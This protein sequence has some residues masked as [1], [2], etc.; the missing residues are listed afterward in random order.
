MITLTDVIRQSIAAVTNTLAEKKCS[1][2]SCGEADGK[3][4]ADA[5]RLKK[6]YPEFGTF[7]SLSL[8]SYFLG[9]L[10][11]F[12]RKQG[13]VKPDQM[14]AID[15]MKDLFAYLADL[16]MKED[17]HYRF[18]TRQTPSPAAGFLDSWLK[19]AAPFSALRARDNII[20]DLLLFCDTRNSTHLSG[21]VMNDI[22]YL[23]HSLANIDERLTGREKELL[24][25][26]DRE[27]AKVKKA[28][29]D[30]TV[31]EIESYGATL[32][33]QD[34]ERLLAEAKAELDELIGLSGIKHE[35]RRL[36]AFLRIRRMR[37]ELG[38]AVADVTL[39]FVFKGN[40]G[41]GKTT[42]ARILGKIF[43]G[44]GYLTGGQLV[45][46]DR[47]GLVAEYLGQTAVKT[48]KVAESALDGILFIDEAYSLSRSGSSG[49]DNYGREAIET[50]LKFME[51]N[52]KKLVVVVAGYPA[53]MDEFIDTNPG[54]KSRFTR[55][56]DFADFTPA[57]LCRITQLFLK[58]AQYR[59]TQEGMNGLR[60][61]LTRAYEGRNEGFGNARFARNLFEETLQN[62]AMRLTAGTVAP[63]KEA[64]M[65]LDLADLPEKLDGIAS[66]EPSRICEACSGGGASCPP[67]KEKNVLDNTVGG[68]KVG[69]WLTRIPL[70]RDVMAYREVT[71]FSPEVKDAAPAETQ[72]TAQDIDEA[73]D[74]LDRFR[75]FIAKAFPETAAEDGLIESPLQPIPRMQ[76]AL[77]Q[78]FGEQLPGRLFLKCDN[79]LPVS[80]SI[81]ARGGIYEVLKFAEEVALAEGLLPTGTDT[82]ALLTEEARKVF[83]GYKIAVGSTGNLGLSIGI[84]GARFGFHVTVHMSAEAR[85]WK[86]DLLRRH[87]VEVVEHPGD[88]GLAVATGRRQAEG[89]PHCHF[90]DDENST[91]LFL[92][93]A[94]A[95][96]RVAQQLAELAVPVDENH[97]LFVYLPCGVGGG[98]GGIAFGLKKIFG[99]HVHCFFAEP[100]HA[101]CMLVGLATG[102]HNEVSVQDFGL[103]GKTAADGL[104]V[105][106]ASGFIGRVMAPLLDG[107]FTVDDNTMFSLLALLADSEDIR[108]EPS[109]LAGMAG[110]IRLVAENENRYYTGWKAKMA[111]ATHLVWGTGGRMVPEEEMKVYY[112]R[113]KRLAG[114]E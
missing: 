85:Q 86:K 72:P 55:Y 107:V 48:K 99:D 97:P 84:M 90:I 111:E 33:R 25:F 9:F 14:L 54:L 30:D 83:A 105:G 20:L 15:G 82:A 103:D 93:Y 60:H 49:G 26:L 50:L 34:S 12:F 51:D 88:Y 5:G 4:A 31:F 74:R 109:A 10:I 18:Q 32:A 114:L 76:E 3:L 53:L 47:A 95:A 101:P 78:R 42:V 89:D 35:V 11:L 110:P 61:L 67:G 92:G 44:L 43:K 23:V 68:K 66:G 8:A 70:L 96:R 17:P 112:A 41:T 21:R 46:T 38:L 106:R 57:E 80:G 45:E 16:F 91:D 102:L 7:I 94:V 59:F 108:M 75:P 79:L 29:G 62:Q 81:K 13:P 39:H 24:D 100:T 36:E 104:A 58:K 22:R 77:S 6:D 73:A 63:D 71:W 52:R 28:I 56:L 27:S 1:W 37:E 40:P 19:S 98:P 64:L 69:E 113:G 65:I 87:G 2:D